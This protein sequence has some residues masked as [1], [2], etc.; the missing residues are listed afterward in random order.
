MSTLNAIGQINP[1]L[2]RQVQHSVG[3]NRAVLL[4]YWFYQIDTDQLRQR[5]QS[6]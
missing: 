6:V 5:L 4:D 1:L 3:I 2:L